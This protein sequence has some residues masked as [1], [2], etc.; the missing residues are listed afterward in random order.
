[1]SVDAMTRKADVDAMARKVEVDN[2]ILLRNYYRIANN[3]LR[4]LQANIHRGEK[5]NID[6][7]IILLRYSSLVTETIPSHQDYQALHPKERAV[8]K[9]RLLAVL[10]ELEGLK[11]EFQHQ[12]QGIGEVQVTAQHYQLSNKENHRYRPVENSLGPPSTNNKAS[13]DYDN[14]WAITNAPSSSTWRQSKHSRE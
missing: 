3:L 7:C 8:S 6:L 2:R 1:M 5:N 10:N 9:T 11:P 4:Q 13:S 12:F 14:Q